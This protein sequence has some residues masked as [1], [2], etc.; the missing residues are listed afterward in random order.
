ME[1][2]TAGAA[3]QTGRAV[4]GSGE[5]ASAAETGPAQCTYAKRAPKAKRTA[6]A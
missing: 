4:N 5:G 6:A 1:S 3:G 2:P